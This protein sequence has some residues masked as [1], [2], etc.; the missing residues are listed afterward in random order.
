MN[1]DDL[2]EYTGQMG[3]LQWLL[4]TGV[5]CL[6]VYCM[7]SVNLIFV[8]GEMDHW[9]RVD[10]LDALPHD[11]QKSIAI[12]AAAETNEADSGGMIYSRCSMYAANWSTDATWWNG[13]HDNG[14]T[15]YDVVSCTSW[16]YDQ[17]QYSST[18]VSRASTHACNNLRVH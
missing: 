16:V 13:S 15:D 5:C 2:Y 17:S 11:R 12:P 14:T 9:C 6:S 8:G 10:E 3:R 4:F 18:I 7:E 1:Y